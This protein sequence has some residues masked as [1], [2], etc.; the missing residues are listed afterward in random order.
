MLCA[1]MALAVMAQQDLPTFAK[2]EIVDHGLYIPVT[3]AVRHSAVG[4]SRPETELRHRII[5]EN[6]V[7]YELVH[8]KQ[9]LT[10]KIYHDGSMEFLVYS[11]VDARMRSDL[12]FSVVGVSGTVVGLT[13]ERPFMSAS[14]LE[15]ADP[16]LYEVFRDFHR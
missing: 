14:Q 5:G 6:A 8:R 10:M 11:E 16:A 12:D 1:L 3:G 2:S 13:I 4:V 15:Q 9:P 7:I